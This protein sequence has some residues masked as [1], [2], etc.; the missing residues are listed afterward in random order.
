[1]RAYLLHEP[2]NHEQKKDYVGTHDPTLTREFIR[3]WSCS[4]RTCCGLGVT[5]DCSAI[6][7]NYIN[8]RVHVGITDMLGRIANPGSISITILTFPLAVPL[9][10]EDHVIRP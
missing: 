2:K 9:L 4:T 6:I 3:D 5:L 10:K 8:H 7:G 1:M